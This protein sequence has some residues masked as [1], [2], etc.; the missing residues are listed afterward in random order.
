MTWYVN[1][2]TVRIL[3][4]L[5]AAID[6]LNLGPRLDP[7]TLKHRATKHTRLS[8][9]GPDDF[10][11]P[12]Q[13]ATQAFT[14]DAHLSFFGRLVARDVLTRALTT[15]L[16]W[17][18]LH[19]DSDPRL[20]TPLN[21]PIII[22]GLPR[23]GTTLLHRLLSELPEL[24]PLY[25][26]EL[27]D[28]LPTTAVAHRQRETRS[29]IGVLRRLAP[30]LDVKHLLDADQPEEEVSLFDPSFWTPTFW[31][32]GMVRSYLDW[33]LQADPM[34]G[35]QIYADLLRVLQAE[36]PQRRFVLK[37]PNHT[38]YI[39]AIR[40]VMPSA[41]VV[42]THRDPVPVVASY[43]SLMRSVHRIAAAR[44]DAEAAGEDCLRLWG[45]HADRCLRVRAGMA[46]DAVCDV[47]FRDLV[48]DLEGQVCRVL[49]HADV[50][51]PG[52]LLERVAR[53]Q[54]R[55]GPK[56]EYALGDYGLSEAQVRQRF[57]AYRE[58]FLLE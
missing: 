24:R 19:A 16:R 23:S 43:A 49:R 34:P 14:K 22:A 42:Q 36:Q 30:E 28:L 10:E 46:P 47:R 3:N 2:T 53:H 45:H 54:E 51:V 7:D 20:K 6:A 18:E 33:Y 1:N 55:H 44:W 9:F 39:D 11:A 35:Y 50:A 58:R 31:R 17:A 27:Q 56:H 4:T 37:M 38:G 32:F 29:R 5:G 21:R 41:V 40:A 12:L 57:R 52:D 25:T 48:G 13:L 8:S 15:R 26:W